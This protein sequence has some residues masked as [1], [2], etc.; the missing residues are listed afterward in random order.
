MSKL[1]LSSLVATATEHEVDLYDHLDPPVDCGTYLLSVEQ[2]LSHADDPLLTAGGT[3]TLEVQGPR[4]RLLPEHVLGCFPPPGARDIAWNRLPH[5]ALTR[6]TLPWERNVADFTDTQPWMALLVLREGEYAGV[7]PVATTVGALPEFL[8]PAYVGVNTNTQ[9]QIIR[10]KQDHLAAILIEE[11][12]LKLSCHARRLPVGDQD[13]RGDEDGF[14][15]IVMSN[16][17]CAPGV[18]HL[19]CLVSLEGQTAAI[20]D[21]DF[22]TFPPAQSQVIGWEATHTFV[23]LHS[24]EF[25]TGT[26]GDF[27]ALVRKLAVGRLGGETGAAR[28][29]L[30]AA[31]ASAPRTVAWQGPLAP[32]PPPRAP[33]ID[34]AQDLASSASEVSSAGQGSDRAFSFATAFELGRMLTLAN[35]PALSALQRFRAVPWD[36][37]LDVALARGLLADHPEL[38]PEFLEDLR[39]ALRTHHELPMPDLATLSMADLSGVA[40]LDASVLAALTAAR[41][42]TQA[43]RAAALAARAGRVRRLAPTQGADAAEAPFSALLSAVAHRDDP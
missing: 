5:I 2:A 19:A 37:H 28:L 15:A 32:E 9:L 43:T 29:P 11:L 24:W 42:A 31:D 34:T 4:L 16:R 41:G 33:L 21:R 35:Q 12:D 18:R 23:V 17:L 7:G 6:R 26:D 1:N 30:D 40:R 20:K 39:A 13:A 36:L 27:E 10:V 3:F 38:D 22:E 8:R 14:I 25:T